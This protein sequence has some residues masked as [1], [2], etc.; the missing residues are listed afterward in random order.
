[1]PIASISVPTE[2]GPLILTFVSS[3]LAEPKAAPAPAAEKNAATARTEPPKRAKS[4]VAGAFTAIP[5]LRDN[6][7]AS[8]N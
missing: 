1:V 7:F 4:D 8:G 5:E 2:N 6:P 3:P